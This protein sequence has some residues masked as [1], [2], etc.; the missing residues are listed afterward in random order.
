MVTVL[1]TNV[2]VTTDSRDLTVPL[3][4]AFA[5]EIASETVP[6]LT[7]LATATPALLV[8]LVKSPLLA[9]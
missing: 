6:A 9:V 2:F 5:L 3:K 7:A 8:L 4:M 1:T